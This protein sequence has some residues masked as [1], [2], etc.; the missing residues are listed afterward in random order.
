MENFAHGH[1]EKGHRHAVGAVDNF[2]AAGFQKVANKVS[3]EGE[4]G[5]EHALVGHVKASFQ[6]IRK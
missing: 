5:D 6:V 3:A 2:P 4:Q 1:G